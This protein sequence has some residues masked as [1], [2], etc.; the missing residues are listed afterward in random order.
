MVRWKNSQPS[1]SSVAIEPTS[2]S[3]RSGNRSLTMRYASM[4]PSGSFQGSKRET[5]SI[6]GRSMSRPN[7]LTM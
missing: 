1:G 5:W 6:S 2:A 3:W 7:W 4:T